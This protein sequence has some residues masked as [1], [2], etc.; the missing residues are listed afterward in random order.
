MNVQLSAGPPRHWLVHPRAAAGETH[1]AEVL[2][3]I[4]ITF[5]NEGNNEVIG[6]FIRFFFT[7]HLIPFPSCTDVIVRTSHAVKNE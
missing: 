5:T 3:L 1:G 4:T 2:R 7:D 6:A